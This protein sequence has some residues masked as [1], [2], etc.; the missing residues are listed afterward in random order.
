MGTFTRGGGHTRKDDVCLN[1]PCGDKGDINGGHGLAVPLSPGRAGQGHWGQGT[2]GMGWHLPAQGDT[3]VTP[4]GIHREGEVTPR[5]G[6]TVPARTHVAALRGL[7]VNHLLAAGAAENNGVRTRK[8]CPHVPTQHLG[9][10]QAP[11]QPGGGTQ[12]GTKPPCPR[13]RRKRQQ[14]D[15]VTYSFLSETK[16]TKR[17][18]L[19]CGGGLGVP[20]GSGGVTHC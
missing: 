6:D 13:W 4:F 15:G 9:T 16:G 3:G 1:S 10:P 2:M 8:H 19:G 14:R 20:G 7:A 11:S 5:G 18:F 12:R 17:G